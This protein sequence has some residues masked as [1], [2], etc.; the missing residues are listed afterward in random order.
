MLIRHH[1]T[2]LMLLNRSNRDKGI[3]TTVEES[4]TPS[5]NVG[6]F[7]SAPIFSS[8]I[9]W[10]TVPAW[11]ISL[12][13]ALWS[14]MLDSLKAVHIDLELNKSAPKSVPGSKA[15]GKMWQRIYQR[16]PLPSSWRRQSPSPSP[17]VA[18]VIR[19][20]AKKTILLDYGEWPIWNGVKAMKTGHILLGVCL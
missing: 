5:Y 2:F 19:S 10:A 1:H 7:H 20:T 8:K 12:Y 14:A 16:L 3:I 15:L 18:T 9:V 6:G 11:V 4:E 17:R 13:S